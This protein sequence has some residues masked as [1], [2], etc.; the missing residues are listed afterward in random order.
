VAGASR[1]ARSTDR[2]S[3]GRWLWRLVRPLGFKEGRRT[4][5]LEATGFHRSKNQCSFTSPR[6]SGVSGNPA[7][8]PMT[9]SVPHSGQIAVW[10]L[11]VHSRISR[12]ENVARHWK[13]PHCSLAS[14]TAR[15]RRA[16]TF[17]RLTFKMS[18][19]RSGRDSCFRSVFSPPFQFG[20]T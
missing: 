8:D 20:R 17:H 19:G 12:G 9:A 16:G 1:A 5:I 6:N 4:S 10:P 15:C 2:D 14:I 13:Q 18:H 3:H 11:C 7:L